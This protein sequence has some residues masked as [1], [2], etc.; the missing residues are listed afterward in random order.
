MLS[1]KFALFV[2]IVFTIITGVKWLLRKMLQIEK[3]K[4]PFFSYNHINDAHRK[5][6][7][8]IR[9]VSLCA[10]IITYKLVSIEDYPQ[11]IILVP[12]FIILLDFPV[13]AF[14]E[15]KQSPESKQYIFNY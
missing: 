14:F 5:F 6:D 3:V 4:K 9:I 1:A 15:W 10:L 7:W 12:T 2:L 13:R 11:S 8:A